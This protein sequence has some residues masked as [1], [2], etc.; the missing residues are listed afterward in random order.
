MKSLRDD[1]GYNQIWEETAATQIRAERRCDYLISLMTA[2]SEKRILEIGCGRGFMSHRLAQVTG[3]QVLGID[4]CDSFI[5]NAKERYRLPNLAFAARDF[6][7]SEPPL[8]VPFDYIVGNGVLHHLFGRLSLALARMNSMLTAGGRIIFL[9]PN[10]ENPLVRII[11]RTSFGRR[12]ANL[13]PGEMAFSRKRIQKL[14]I[15]AEYR[16]VQVNY[17]D[18]LLPGMPGFLVRPLILLGDRLEKTPLLRSFS[19]S[20]GISADR[21]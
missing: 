10:L 20:L 7:I 17:K 12:L 19:Q 15:A 16:N 9:E 1:R 4:L 11:F 8:P 13:E 3:M 2:G 14:L 18:F 21:S 6:L 5:R